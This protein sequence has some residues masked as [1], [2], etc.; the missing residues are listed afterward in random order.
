MSDLIAREAIDPSWYRQVLGQYPTGVCAVTATEEDGRPVAMVVGSFT[1]VSL[2]PSLIAFFPD[3]GSSSWARLRRIDHFC[4]NILSANQEAVCRALAS[5]NSEKF[6]GISHRISKHGNPVIDG[7]VGWIECDRHSITE[8]GD[9][10]MVLGRIV[11]LDIESGDLPLLFFQGGYG[12]FAP[13]SL[14]AADTHGL[15]LLQLKHVDRARPEMERIA[16]DLSARCI[17][18][19]RAGDELAVAASAGQ[20]RLHSTPNLVGQRLPFVPP[21]GS[22][23]AAWLS[24]AEISRWLSRSPKRPQAEFA[25]RLA[26]VRERGFSIGLLNEAQRAFSAK[27]SALAHGQAAEPGIDLTTLVDDLAYDPLDL[28][29]EARAAIRIISMPVFDSS[30]EVALVLTLHDFPKP[31]A[32]SGVDRYIS[33]LAE[34]AAIV[35][36][37][38]GGPGQPWLPPH[39]R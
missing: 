34:A 31:P 33:R 15:T 11:E 37:S 1:S 30:G 29:V 5:K 28:T 24:E 22:V 8:A 18:T 4:V 32:E 36:Q 2:N 19:V 26:V 12:R 38:L 3:R 9:H 27:L 35:T 14:G 10:D 39:P 17:A 7:A 20:G 23:F 21:T 13:S 25:K 6:T 16:S